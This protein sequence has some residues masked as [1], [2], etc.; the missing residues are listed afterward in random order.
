MKEKKMK[1]TILLLLLASVLGLMSSP[2]RAGVLYEDP[3]GGWTYIYTGDAAVAG[4]TDNFDSLDGT[5]D[6][7]N[8]SDQ[9]DGTAIGAG[10]PGGV[11]AWALAGDGRI[12]LQDTGDPRDY[13]FSDPGSNRKI[14][15]GHSIT[16]DLGAA[17]DAILDD[18]VTISF[19]AR[20]ATGAP[21]DDLHPAGGAGIS[22]WPAGGDG[23][24]THDGG[25][26][27]FSVRQLTDDMI[28]S[29]ALALSSDDLG[30]VDELAGQEGLVMNKLNGNIP[31]EDV[32][33][34]GDEPGTVNIL[35]LDPRR[36]HEFWITI[37][38]DTTA[39]GTHLVRV[40]RD[41]SL[42]ATEFYVT[43]GVGN[44]YEDSYL[45]MGVGATPQSGAIDVDFFA[46]KA[47]VLIPTNPPAP[48]NDHCENATPIS[49]VSDLAFDTREATF[50]GPGHCMTSPN[51]WYCYTASCTG[52]ATVSLRGSRYDTMLAVYRGCECYPTRSRLIG[53]NDDY[54]WLQSQLTFNVVAGS[55]YLIEVGGYW[56]CT[57]QGV[58]TITCEE[59][60][61]FEFDLGDAPDSSNYLSATMTAYTVGTSKVQ[62]KFPTTFVGSHA[63][64][65]SGPVHLHPLAVAYLGEDVTLETEADKGPDQDGINNIDPA[66]DAAD[67]DGADDGVVFPIWMPHCDWTTF[68]YVVNVVDP[69]R[70][71]WVNVWC[72]WNRDGDW[73]DDSSTDPDLSCSGQYVSEWAVQ[74]QY[75][76]GLP[77]GLHHITTPAFLSWHP[78]GGPEE[79]WMR[80]TLSEQPWKGGE[81]PGKLGNGGSGPVAGYEVGETEDYIFAPDRRCSICKDLNDN[82]EMDFD[83]LLILLYQWLE[84]CLD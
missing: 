61:P 52:E 80:I 72:D 81:N 84:C 32:D 21:L 31:S 34:Q 2:A 41:G 5:W 13:G 77:V 48:P 83:D 40:Y 60:A 22:P 43:A 27:N 30:D 59:E 19:R 11:S 53:C 74:N 58:L 82:G 24:V 14:M 44:D 55:D 45:G 47:E 25:K 79:I 57:G 64:G 69:T 28:I 78:E 66:S 62:A 12:R 1:T 49:E 51:I 63:T 38:P 54:W 4:P 6:H 8:G 37:Q 65:P 68:D 20:V 16:N 18:G 73:D 39:T 70:D 10:R 26:G 75:L 76:F 71:L 67:M 9:W 33:L 23:Y 35:E 50:D 56:R 17:G 42:T 46:Y 3:A 29:F 15:F 36:W 7:N